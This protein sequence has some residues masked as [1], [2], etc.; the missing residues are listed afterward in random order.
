MTDET[1]VVLAHQLDYKKYDYIYPQYEYTKVLPQAGTQTVT[2]TVA[3]GQES[4]FEF[5]SK[6]FN[7]SR[8]V[9]SYTWTPVA[10]GVGNFNWTPVDCMHHF[11][12]I[13]VYTKAGL[14]L[15]DLQNPGNFTKMVW[16]R[17]IKLEDF[18]NY[19]DF[20]NGIGLSKML[21]QC[22]STAAANI[23]HDNTA[24]SV[25]YIE[26]M[27]VQPGTNNGANPVFNIK[28][29][30]GML[31]ETLLAEDKDIYF[32]DNIYVRLV[33]NPTVNT[34]WAANSGVDPTGGGAP[35][36]YAGNVTITNLQFYM[37]IEKNPLIQSKLQSEFNSKGISLLIPYPNYNKINLNGQSQSVNYKWNRAHGQRL[38]R[39]YHSA[40]NN[41]EALNTIY[42][43]S[44][45]AAAKITSFYTQLDSMRRQQFDLNCANLDDYFI[46]QDKIKG[47][48]ILSSN[49]YY[50]NWCWLEDFCNDAKEI[51]ESGNGGVDQDNLRQ[52]IDL[53]VEKK[54]DMIITTPGAGGVQLNH[55]TY[56]I[57]Q[58]DLLITPSQVI[59]N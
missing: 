25:A 50:Y 27:Y 36:A 45:V 41:A 31:L 49:S 46:N 48:I 35:I 39:I 33:W 54:W 20:G 30:L 26:P 51:T 24:S 21:R 10:P 1:R 17:N 3:G 44:N 18:L 13:Q 59:L 28:F 2:V 14:F 16:K 42:D 5:P 12:Q 23:R 8:T 47:S 34:V 57:T 58:R 43:Q 53:T 19:D 37:C 29:P 32:G 56:A 6:F 9:L 55:Y 52:G 15:L 11:R 22:N 7:F 40:F 38:M 4:I